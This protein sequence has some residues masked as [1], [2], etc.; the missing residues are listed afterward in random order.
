M[1]YLIRAGIL[2]MFTNTIP[3]IIFRQDRDE[4]FLMAVHKEGVPF[5][6]SLEESNALLSVLFSS[7]MDGLAF[8]TPDYQ[9]RYANEAMA[10]MVKLPLAKVLGNP[11][12][13][14]IPGW[15]HQMDEVCQKTR[16][17]GQPFATDK[18]YV[19]N[20]ALLIVAAQLILQMI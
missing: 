13:G 5:N 6:F 8:I 9:V 7:S 2:W 3:K 4:V 14:L 12:A 11:I 10:R 1:F 18:D 19:G 17:T 20:I 15:S 16:L